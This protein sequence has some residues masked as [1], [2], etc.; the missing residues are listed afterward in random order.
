MHK[1]YKNEFWRE[2][3]YYIKPILERFEMLKYQWIPCVCVRMRCCSRDLCAAT[4]TR[5]TSTPTARCGRRLIT[6]ICDRLSSLWWPASITNVAKAAP[7][8]GTERSFS[9]IVRAVD[10]ADSFGFRA[11]VKIAF[12]IV[13]YLWLRPC[14]V[15]QHRATSCS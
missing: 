8:S 2:L 1:L 14:N 5:S 15:V 13:S 11:H 7:T 6:L 10:W 4:W 3:R 9:S 12:R